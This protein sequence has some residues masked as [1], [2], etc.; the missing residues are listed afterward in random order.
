MA[1]LAENRIESSSEVDTWQ[2]NG[3]KGIR[4][5]KENFMCETGITTVLKSVARIRLVKTEKPIVSVTVN[6]K[7]C[8]SAIAL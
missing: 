7:L 1:V 6:C 3:K 4:L 8:R 2:N 5:C